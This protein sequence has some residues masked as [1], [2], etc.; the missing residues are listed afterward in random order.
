M[1]NNT[2][3]TRKSVAAARSLGGVRK[4]TLSK[5]THHSL[6][7]EFSDMILH[8]VRNQHTQQSLVP[9]SS[10]PK[11]T[12]ARNG[13]SQ[14]IPTHHREISYNQFTNDLIE[15]EY[16]ELNDGL[17]DSDMADV[18]RSYLPQNYDGMD[19][20]GMGDSDGSYS[21]NSRNVS[22]TP[23]PELSNINFKKILTGGEK[24]SFSDID[25]LRFQKFEAD[26]HTDTVVN[27]DDR[28]KKLVPVE[29]KWVNSQKEDIRKVSIIGS[30]SNWKDV[31]R[32][33]KS[34]NYENEYS[35]TVNLTL[36]VHKLLYIVNNEYR[37]SGQLPTATDQEGIFFNWFEVLDESHLFNHIE[38]Q[39]NHIGASTDY[40]ANIIQTAGKLDVDR[41]QKK[42]NSFLTRISKES[43]NF[44]H[45][46]FKDP[47]TSVSGSR[48]CTPTPDDINNS[49]RYVSYHEELSSSF[50][51]NQPREA[52]TYSNEIPEM[53]VNYEYFKDKSPNYELPEPPQ[54]PA[55]LNNVLL[56]KI[57]NNQHQNHANS[58]PNVSDSVKILQ[59]GF[60]RPT[61]RRA[62]SSYYA[63][64]KE[65]LHL[66]V[67]NHVI[68][69][70]LMTTSIRNDVLTVA[71]ITRYSGKFVTQIMHSPAD[72]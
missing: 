20:D 28:D 61:L 41:I 36:G 59:D 12:G 9:I 39:Q 56:N 19:I 29:I 65:A 2:S 55:H 15:D 13:S 35:V 14:H 38:N 10:A 40:D 60:K 57:S 52:V 69:N 44:E 34:P 6:D 16:N 70:H 21:K 42:S 22:E 68:L 58:I 37:V 24:K 7:E 23:T 64:N 71:C 8:E 17:I 30:F 25:E 26:S 18:S 46:E 54:L 62:D 45:V 48:D 4:S 32:L 27:K 51:A 47:K 72:N 1:G 5:D 3:S 49:N 11:E 43:E 31:I 50:L 33:K 53:F 66:S 63:S 67:P